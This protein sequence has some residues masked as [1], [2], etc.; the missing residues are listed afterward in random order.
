MDKSRFNLDISVKLQSLVTESFELLFPKSRTADAQV[1]S[2]AAWMSVTKKLNEAFV[3]KG[4]NFSELQIKNHW[5][6]LKKN[7]K[8]SNSAKKK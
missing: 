3:D 8:Q 5:A 1:K 4:A 7:A 2:N 6:Y